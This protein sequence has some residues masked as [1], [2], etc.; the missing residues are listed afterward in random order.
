MEASVL[1]IFKYLLLDWHRFNHH[2]NLWILRNRK[3]FSQVADKM[4]RAGKQTDLENVPF[5][6]LS[7]TVFDLETTGFFPKI[8]DEVISI[9]AVKINLNHISFPEQFYEVVRPV[10]MPSKQIRELTGLSA[11]Q[12]KSGKPFP[13][14]MLNFLDFSRHTILVAHPASFD[15]HFLYE[16]AKRWGLPPYLPRA[17]DSYELAN[18]I[19][20]KEKNSLDQ[21]IFKLEVE[22]KL[23]HHALNDAFM[24]AEI[25]SKLMDELKNRGIHTLKEYK[26]AGAHKK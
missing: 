3:Q 1:Q 25:F 20:P 19:F 14:A 26:E 22:N 6:D 17:V 9:G 24:T 11:A 23:R 4:L 18:Y 15:V 16:L 8:G 2:K 13:S 10:K 7:F 21:L 5:H 12:I